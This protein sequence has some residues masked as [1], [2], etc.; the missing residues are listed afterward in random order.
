M[1]LLAPER[2]VV[3][4]DVC[5][6]LPDSGLVRGRII[7]CSGD[8]GLSLALSLCSR[9]TQQGSWLGVVGVAHLGVLAAVEH[10]VALERMVLVQPPNT[11]R[12]WSVT[13]S[14]VID[15]F[16]L[17]VV[18]VPARLSAND[19]RRVQTR[20]QSRRAVMIIVDNMTL[21]RST[22]RFAP[23][24]EPDPFVADVILDTKTKSWSGIDNGSGYLQHRDVSIRVSGR[25]VARQREHLV[26]RRF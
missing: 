11:S 4:D 10:G 23:E 24:R 22:S 13:V 3:A 25:R 1:Q 21:S 16:D 9:A 26:T 15:G 14:A 7:R 19:A 8:A 2:L 5:K 6:L 17:L 18:A 12:E 20:L